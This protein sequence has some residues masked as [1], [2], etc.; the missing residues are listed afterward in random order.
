MVY[1]S[2][3]NYQYSFKCANDIEKIFGFKILNY[4]N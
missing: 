2:G 1:L 4:S 3:L